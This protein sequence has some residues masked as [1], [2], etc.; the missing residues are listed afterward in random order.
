MSS[1]EIG[2]FLDINSFAGKANYY[3][4]HVAQ[5]KKVLCIAGKRI[6]SKQLTCTI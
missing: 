6:V 1:C 2:L 4:T 5:K 3:G